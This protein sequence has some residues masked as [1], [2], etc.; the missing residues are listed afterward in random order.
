MRL[1]YISFY[2]VRKI[3]KARF[4]SFFGKTKGPAGPG[5]KVIIT[6]M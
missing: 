2:G 1:K 3:F 5:V 4:K 6:A